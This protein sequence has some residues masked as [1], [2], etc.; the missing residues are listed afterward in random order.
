LAVT[1]GKGY[2]TVFI[3]PASSSPRMRL[4]VAIDL[5][6][7]LASDVAAAQDRFGDPESLRFTDPQQ[8]HITLWFLGSV[9]DD[10]V[11]RVTD[12]V[13]A[14]VDEA[15]VE[16]FELAVGGFGVFP[17]LDYISVVW[18]GVRQ[19]VTEL[20]RL[21]DCLETQLTPLGFEPD[22]HTFTPHVTLARMDDARAKATVQRVVREEDPT[23]GSFRV[24]DVRLRRSELTADGPEYSTVASVPL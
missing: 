22:D 8:A 6:D 12:A 17:S 10:R 13:A 16:P 23:I 1:E 11:D 20:T 3:D 5:P 4:F 9:D 2:V 7:R 14:A 21:H 15:S 24:D 19:G 18:T